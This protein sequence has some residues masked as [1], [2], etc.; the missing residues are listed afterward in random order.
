MNSDFFQFDRYIC[1]KEHTLSYINCL[2]C[3]LR[4]SPGSLTHIW[5]GLLR[6]SYEGL[7]SEL[8]SS[9]VQTSA[10]D[11]VY[12]VP[13]SSLQIGITKPPVDWVFFY[14]H[15]TR[16]IG[17]F[18]RGNVSWSPLT[19]L[20]QCSILYANDHK[21]FPFTI[22]S[23]GSSVR[24]SQTV[25]FLFIRGTDA[26]VEKTHFLMRFMLFEMQKIQ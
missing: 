21:R 20:Y 9:R 17:I 26:E 22:R 24:T 13:V 3:R 2:Y 6:A 5:E 8:H 16:R 15:F 14:L 4:S 7:F 23:N 25:R 10:A 11:P 1:H 18:T 12:Y 19:T